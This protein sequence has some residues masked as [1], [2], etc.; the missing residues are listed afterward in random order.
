VK[1]VKY[2]KKIRKQ[3]GYGRDRSIKRRE[4]TR[5]ET[6]R[7]TENRNLRKSVNSPEI[8]EVT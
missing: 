5:T 4:I 6:R 1:E 8:C 3:R 2:Q 7:K